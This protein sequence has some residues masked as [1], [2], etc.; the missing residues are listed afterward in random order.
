MA[1]SH[2]PRKIDFQRLFIFFSEAC[3]CTNPA[4][5]CGINRLLPEKSCDG[6]LGDVMTVN[7]TYR[8]YFE[9]ERRKYRFRILNGSVSRFFKLALSDGSPMIQIANDGNLFPQPVVLTQLDEQALPYDV[10]IDFSR[11]SIGDK[12]WFVN[13]CEHKDGKKPAADL[14]LQQALSGNSQDPCVGKFLEFRIVRDPATPDV[15]QV[16]ATMIPN[17]DLSNI[18]VA[19]Q[20]T[21]VFG[22]GARFRRHRS[23]V[24]ERHIRRTVPDCSVSRQQRLHH[25]RCADPV[26]T[27]GPDHSRA[28]AG[29]HY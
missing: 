5:Q 28:P 4:E 21:F 25:Q 8:P 13:L 22:S 18:P 24:R 19:R 7:L 14:S 23:N 29:A 2:L 16:P 20:R 9:V 15:S 27:S 11:Y 10:V 1:C 6:F 17:P 12:V 3:K 26:G